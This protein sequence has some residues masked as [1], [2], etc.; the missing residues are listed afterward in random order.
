MSLKVFFN[1]QCLSQLLKH[2]S[3]EKCEILPDFFSGDFNDIFFKTLETK[4]FLDCITI[5]CRLFLAKKFHS[6]ARSPVFCALQDLSCL[7]SDAPLLY[8]DHAWLDTS[9]YSKR[10][11]MAGSI[12][13]A[14]ERA[15][16][17]KF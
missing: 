4:L 10:D 12:P 6:V 9:I 2:A 1:L 13:E 16:N 14:S 7:I 15:W 17:L 11:M 3:R 5:S 8:L